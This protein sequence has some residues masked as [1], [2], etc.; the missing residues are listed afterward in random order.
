M[1]QRGAQKE[2]E[3]WNDGVGGK[4]AITLRL[5]PS[6]ILSPD[7]PHLSATTC[8][9][10]LNARLKVTEMLLEKPT[11]IEFTCSA[12]IVM[13]VDATLSNTDLNR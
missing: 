1:V 12:V 3:G 11:F 7:I 6:R 5:P 9:H 2:R 13:V 8:T 4:G 10:L